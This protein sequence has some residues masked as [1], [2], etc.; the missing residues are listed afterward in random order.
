MQRYNKQ[1]SKKAYK[2]SIGAPLHSPFV[3]VCEA[4][5]IPLHV[6]ST[7]GGIWI[8]GVK[9]RG[10][11]AIKEHTEEAQPVGEEPEERQLDVIDSLQGIW[12]GPS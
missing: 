12:Y 5:E 1:L 9:V 10:V 8:N 3:Q 4:A 7:L 11:G 6:D 2:F